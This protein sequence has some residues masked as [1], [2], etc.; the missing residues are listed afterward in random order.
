[1]KQ[2]LLLI[3]GLFFLAGCSMLGDMLERGT[4]KQIETTPDASFDPEASLD[5]AR[6]LV[7]RGKTFNAEELLNQVISQDATKQY[8]PAARIELGNIYYQKEEYE[9]AAEEYKQ[10]LEVH[11]HH[12]Y[13]PLVQYRYGMCFLKQIKSVDTGYEL[14]QNALKE[15]RKLQTNYPRNPYMAETEQRIQMALGILAEHEYYV[16]D[17][18]YK[19]GAYK[20]ASQRLKMLLREYPH[21]ANE[22]EALLKLA[23]SYKKLNEIHR[24]IETY[25]AI[26]RNFPKSKYEEKAR[27]EIAVLTK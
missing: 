19:K 27:A 6:T 23:K 20:A 16:A 17:F 7:S 13:A 15:F 12:E 14:A 2:K 10:F 4:A 24:A 18:Y 25:R 3:I 9:A 11:A 26:I 5:E 21:P 1:M 8:E 22:A